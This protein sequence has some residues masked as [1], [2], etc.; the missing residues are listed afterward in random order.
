MVDIIGHLNTL[1]TRL[2][3]KDQLINKLYSHILS[4]QCKLNLF[5]VQLK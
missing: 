4:F 3:G 1:N 5:K 2:Q